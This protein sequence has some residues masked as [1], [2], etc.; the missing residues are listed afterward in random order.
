M[1]NTT[2][3]ANKNTHF[4]QGKEKSSFIHLGIITNHISRKMTFLRRINNKHLKKLREHKGYYLVSDIQGDL[5]VSQQQ[6]H[7][8]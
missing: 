5:R 7:I 8:S 6:Y 3:K 4:E 2:E 1:E